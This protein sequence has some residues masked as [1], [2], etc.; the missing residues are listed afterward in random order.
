MKRILDVNKKLNG[1]ISEN[2]VSDSL[3]EIVGEGK[4]Q[5]VI[6]HADSFWSESEY[7][8]LDVLKNKINPNRLI[9]ARLFNDE[10]EYRI[11]RTFMNGKVKFIYRHMRDNSN[12]G[13]SDYKLAVDTS[14]DFYKNKTENTLI[15]RNYIKKRGLINSYDD[16]RFVELKN[17]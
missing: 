17:K 2:S 12:Q 15:I 13:E 5:A 16:M 9:E 3:P 8:D 7:L 10:E 4:F 11:L 14:A 6:V 1:Q